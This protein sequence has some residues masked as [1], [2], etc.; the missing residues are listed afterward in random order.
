[1]GEKEKVQK[2]D[3]SSV[4]ELTKA[5][6]QL[7]NAL[8]RAKDSMAVS[9]SGGAGTP[10]KKRTVPGGIKVKRDPLGNER[11]PKKS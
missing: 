8:S 3:S 7:G 1:M 5:A 9:E 4:G 10:F 11:S 6:R 2:S